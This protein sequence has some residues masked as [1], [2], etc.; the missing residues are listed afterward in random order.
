[1]S[2]ILESEGVQDVMD[3]NEKFLCLALGIDEPAE[4]TTLQKIEL[5]VDAS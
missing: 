1:M 3:L 2:M 5:R 4:L